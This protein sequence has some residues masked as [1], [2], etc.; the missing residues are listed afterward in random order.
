VKLPE[1]KRLVEAEKKGQWQ[2]FKT[3]FAESV[4]D[5]ALL[6]SFIAEQ[7]PTVIPGGLAARGAALGAKALG[8][9]TKAAIGAGTAG[10][11]GT[12]AVMQ[13]AD[14]GADTYDTIYKA[15][16]EKG[17]S[18]EE[19]AA[20]AINRARAAGLSGA[21]L[22]VIANRYLLGRASYGALACR[23]KTW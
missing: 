10:A 12:G 17:L 14:V 18:Q 2:A 5:P 4:T 11:I 7:I 13:G 15:L 9:G 19:A 22:S 16:L 3:A 23:R 8:A 6:T 21:A 20:G 1:T